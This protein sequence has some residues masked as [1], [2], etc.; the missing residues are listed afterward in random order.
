MPVG[1][2][3]SGRTLVYEISVPA[4]VAPDPQADL[5]DLVADAARE[6]PASVLFSRPTGAGWEDVTASAFLDEVTRLAKGLVAVG[7][8]PGD[9][10]GLMSKTRYDWTL[11]D[12]AIWFAGAVTVPIYE[13]SSPEQVAWI[14]GDSGA[15]G[16]VV[17][18]A[19]HAATVEN[20]R[21]DLTA[22]RTV[23]TIEQGD[24]R[25]LAAGGTDVED[26]EIASR[27]AGLQGDS[28]ATLIYTSGTTGRPK[29]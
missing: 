25:E 15:V 20:I 17:E 12:V 21:P 7:V 5:T 29:G 9:R 11:T 4:L 2:D 13:T 10:V 18:T 14:L 1:G 16:V 6:E 19:A 22:L 8:R 3:R 28:V 24:L 23:W 27:R 26:A